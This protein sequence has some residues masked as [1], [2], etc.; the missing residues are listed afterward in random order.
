MEIKWIADFVALA[1]HQSLSQAAEERHVS[2]SGL[3]DSAMCR[4]V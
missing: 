3:P 2:Q 1:Q 4:E